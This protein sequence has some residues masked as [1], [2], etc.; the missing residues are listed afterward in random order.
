MAKIFQFLKYRDK[1][2]YFPHS[3][4]FRGRAYPIPPHF[5]HLGS[6]IARSLI[7]LAEGRKLGKGGLD[8]LKIHLINL[9]GTMK[10]CTIQERLDH[11]NT[12][13]DEIIDSAE[14]PFN[15][16]QWWQMSEAKWQ[17]LACCIE[18]ANAIKSKNPENF[19]SHFPIHQDGSCNGLQHYAAIGR[20]LDG[21]RSVNL[22]PSER[23]NDVYS[24][25]MDIVESKR[26]S[27]EHNNEIAKI[28]K[29]YVHRKV[30]KQTVMT[31]V[32]NVTFYGAVEQIRSKLELYPNLT[33][34]T[35][36]QASSYLASKT[37][38]SIR[39]LFT[40]AQE[41]QDWLSQCAYLISYVRKQS[42]KW[43]TPLGLPIAQPYFKQVDNK[44][45]NVVKSHQE[46]RPNSRKQRNAFAPN[47][48][49]SLDSS[50]M[51]LTALF[52]EQAGIQFVSVHDCFWTHACNADAM[53]KICRDQFVA[54]HSLPLL[55]GLSDFFIKNYGFSREEMEALENAN[56]RRAMEEFNNVLKNV[57]KKG[58]FDLNQVKKSVYFFS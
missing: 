16:R 30:V 32:Y 18:I 49:H 15:G 55:E 9:T 2:I 24:T 35:I 43:E 3:L 47:Y 10:R 7:V 52:C 36:K 25:V 48:I 5:N 29:G 40:S 1:V 46:T 13:I 11:A 54:L 12:I 21:A 14:H 56:I 26:A 34:E 57:P 31:T 50:H 51:M 41:I 8:M 37:F 28:L 45:K 27:E 23:P 39:Q 6:D 42:I 20:D 58:N 19:V 53:N 33:E 38:Q 44:N 4:D 22:M 17:T